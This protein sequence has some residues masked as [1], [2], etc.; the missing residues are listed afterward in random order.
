M[1]RLRA[2]LFGRLRVLLEGKELEGLESRKVQELF[3][4]LVIHRDRPHPR[5]TLASVLW[6]ASST[7][8][9][10]KYLRQALWQLQS[11]VRPSTGARLLE[12][13]SEWV[14][15]S[16]KADLWVDV[17]TFEDAFDLA[18]GVTGAG[19]DD[20]AAQTLRAAANLYEG[21]LLEGWYL[22]WCLYYRERLQNMYLAL[23]AKLMGYCE[24]QQEYEA[25]LVFG[26]RILQ[27][28]RA[29]E[30]AHR[31]MMRLHALAG[32]RTAALRQYERC[33]IAL[34]EEL[35]VAPGRRSKALLRQIQADRIPRPGLIPSESVS[36]ES[37]SPLLL[38][39]LR[40]LRAT[41]ADIQRQIHRDIQSIERA[42]NGPR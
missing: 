24:A 9:S 34:E 26:A 3:C 35:R 21:D 13:D 5:E 17:V 23:L 22:D 37:T 28:D 38:V 1:P 40:E 8:H 12:I 20:A 39:R 11:A 19:L 25:G 42:L 16:P 31:R 15:L 33:R 41:L 6:E 29:Q 10:K 27:V 4:Y 14:S 30:R 7:A 32:D 2:H 18:S 36:Q